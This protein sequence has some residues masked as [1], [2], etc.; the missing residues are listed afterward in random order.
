[1]NY[2]CVFFSLQLMETHASFM[3]SLHGGHITSYCLGSLLYSA[4]LCST[5]LQRLRS[6]P[7]WLSSLLLNQSWISTLFKHAYDGRRTERGV[8]SSLASSVNVGR[9]RWSRSLLHFVTDQRL[10]AE[11]GV[12]VWV[13][14][15]VCVGVCACVGGQ[16]QREGLAVTYLPQ[17]W[18]RPPPSHLVCHCGSWDRSQGPNPAPLRCWQTTSLW[19]HRG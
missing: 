12:C 10:R 7:S 15:K 11:G 9:Q 16:R 18:R 5:S 4:L 8:H 2:S 14:N 1:M 13:F 3:S 19:K 6:G 17:L